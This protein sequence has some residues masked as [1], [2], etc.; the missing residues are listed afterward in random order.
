MVKTSIYIWI[1]QGYLFLRENGVFTFWIIGKMLPQVPTKDIWNQRR[2]TETGTAFEGK[3]STLCRTWTFGYTFYWSNRLYNCRTRSYLTK[4]WRWL[5]EFKFKTSL[6]R[7][8]ILPTTAGWKFGNSLFLRVTQHTI[9]QRGRGE[10]DNTGRPFECFSL[11]KSSW[12][13]FLNKETINIFLKATVRLKEFCIR[14]NSQSQYSFLETFHRRHTVSVQLASVV[15]VVKLVLAFTCTQNLHKLH[16]PSKAKKTNTSSIKAA[17]HICT[18]GM[19]NLPGN[20]LHQG[21]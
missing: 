15:C 20:L 18:S 9:L 2:T 1:Y 16:Q 4:K 12:W 11:R 10:K 3:L 17:S 6:S 14:S 7:E 5:V 8:N 19:Q 13:K 21:G